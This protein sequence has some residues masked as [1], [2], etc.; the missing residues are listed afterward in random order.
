[1]YMAVHDYK[2]ID[3]CF[4]KNLK[5]Y[6]ATVYQINR[7][8]Q[9]SHKQKFYYPDDVITKGCCHQQP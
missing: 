8:I 7:G 1:M 3:G 6:V 9:H 4:N 2:L 5:S